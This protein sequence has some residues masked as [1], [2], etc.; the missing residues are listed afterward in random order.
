MDKKVFENQTFGAK[1]SLPVKP[2]VRQQLAYNSAAGFSPVRLSSLERHWE[3]LKAILSDWECA[4][5]PDPAVDLDSITDPKVSTK[6]ADIVTWAGLQAA[7]HMNS[8][9]DIPPNS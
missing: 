9:E 6:I 5:L 4:M 2:T 1:F 7:I 3:G 8:L